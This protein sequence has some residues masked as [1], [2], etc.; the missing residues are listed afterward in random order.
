MENKMKEQIRRLV[1]EQGADVCGFAGISRFSEAPEG[2]SPLDLFPACRS[3]VVFGIALPRGLF[4][5]EPRLI[6][7]HFNAF[8][9]QAADR[10]A[11]QAARL[12]E[13]E[14]GGTAVP[15]PCDAPY[16]YWNHEK[17]EGRGL[18]SMKHAAVKAGLGAL[19]KN[20]LLLNPEYGSRLTVGAVLTS[21][22]LPSDARCG[23][24]CVEG[25][26]K[27]VKSCPVGAIQNGRVD[28]KLCRTYTYGSTGRGFDTVDCNRCRSVCP[29]RDGTV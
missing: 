25:C 26:S 16:E 3:A 14:F 18:I 17:Q 23:S 6:Y 22:E 13:R 24:Q 28:Q 29:R 7:G 8:S 19:G 21:L 20:S 2:F 10:V 15:L 9:C 11:F 12:I 1:L 5:V 4:R 27:C